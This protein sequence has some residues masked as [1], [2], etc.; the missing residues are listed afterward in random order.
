MVSPAYGEL[1]QLL[2]VDEARQ[3][4]RTDSHRMVITANDST[5]GASTSRT[6]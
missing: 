4:Q 5:C 2:W 6:T 1:R 3:M